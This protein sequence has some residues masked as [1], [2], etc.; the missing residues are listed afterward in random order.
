MLQI[1]LLLGQLQVLD[2]LYQKLQA[3]EVVQLQLQNLKLQNCSSTETIVV[4]IFLKIEHLLPFSI[5]G[6]LVFELFA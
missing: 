1:C 3:V 5:V 6:I 2:Q 4:Q